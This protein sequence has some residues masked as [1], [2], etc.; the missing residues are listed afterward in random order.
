MKRPNGYC[1]TCGAAVWYSMLGC[2]GFTVC[3]TCQWTAMVAF[4][5]IKTK[6]KKSKA[7]KR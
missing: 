1:P 4:N 2:H 5:P 6:T 7:G 3:R